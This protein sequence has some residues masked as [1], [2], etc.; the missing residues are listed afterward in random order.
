MVARRPH[1]QSPLE[2]HGAYSTT[3]TEFVI[4]HGLLQYVHSP[5]RCNN[6]LD[7][8]FSDDPYSIC[9]LDTCVPFS[10]SDHNS[11]KFQLT[12]GKKCLLP[13][14]PTSGGNENKRYF[15]GKANWEG[16]ADTL[17]AI[18]WNDVLNTNVEN[19]YDV[20]C[21][22][23]FSIIDD[24]VPAATDSVPASK[25]KCYYPKSI[26]VM[27]NRKLLVWRKWQTDRNNII[28]KQKYVSIS[29]QCRMAIHEYNMN[30]EKLLIESENLGKFYKHVNDVNRK[31]SIKTGIG[32]LK[33]DTGEQVTDPVDQAKLLHAYFATTFVDDNGV[34][35]DFPAQ[36]PPETFLS[37][38]AF[39]ANDAA[40]KLNKLNADSASGPDGLAPKFLKKMSHFICQP[41][42]VIFELFFLNGYVPSVWKEAY[43]KPIFKKGH[44]H[45]VKK[46]RP[47]SSTLNP[48]PCKKKSH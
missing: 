20:F 12:G 11:V 32:V 14:K 21:R 42:S 15:F 7:L 18:D 45:D 33:S 9:N 19:L 44:V 36:V 10:T 5:T 30:R 6:I 25:S 43:V 41:L 35:P 38:I 17:S 27:Q 26:R 28:L 31:L 24:F 34:L 3:F 47:I 29:K 2:C 4:Q 37:N 48:Y 8:V 22:T 40:K 1:S 39:S 23:L 13:D 46:Y 16:I